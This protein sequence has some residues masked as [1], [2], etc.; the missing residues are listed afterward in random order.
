MALLYQVHLL[1]LFPPAVVAAVEDEGVVV[2]DPLESIMV[3][4]LPFLHLR[5]Y[6]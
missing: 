6:L 3:E 1:I 4:E 5:V 2:G